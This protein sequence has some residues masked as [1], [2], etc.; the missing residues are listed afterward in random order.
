MPIASFCSG[1][2][3]RTSNLRC[4]PFARLSLRGAFVFFVFFPGLCLCCAPAALLAQVTQKSASD[5]PSIQV[6]LVAP[7]QASFTPTLRD[8]LYVLQRGDEITI[9]VFRLPELEET[10]RIR[11]DGKISVLLL[12][13]IDA[14][15]LTTRELRARLFVRYSEFFQEPQVSVILRSGAD[16]KVYVGGE[17]T[18]PG[19]IPLLGD[20]TA[21]AACLQ[22]GG[23]KPTARTDNAILIRNNGHEAPIVEKLNL[24]DALNKGRGDVELKP[25]DVVYVPPSKVA[26]A[27]RFVQQYTRDL[28]PITL[29]GGFSY[30][31]GQPAALF[32][33]H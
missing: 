17:V 14:A 11:P 12:D 1:I 28:L 30:I 7:Q 22:A 19:V 4:S 6:G 3:R 9:K 33:L 10:L 29:T 25:F 5:R 18:Q 31:L 21:L 2:N 16:L 26:R 23:F 24:K 15:G 8:G 20:L 27:D 32:G 13:D